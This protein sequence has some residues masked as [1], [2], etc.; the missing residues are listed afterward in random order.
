MVFTYLKNVRYQIKA[1]Y[2]RNLA[3][4]HHGTASFVHDND[5]ERIIRMGGRNVVSLGRRECMGFIA[6]CKW[7]EGKGYYDDD[8]VG[9]E[10]YMF[11]EFLYDKAIDGKIKYVGFAMQ[12]MEKGY[13]F[14]DNQPKVFRRFEA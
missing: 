9:M 7:G 6:P 14:Y 1:H 2:E 3:Y 5:I 11:R 4:T 10:L 12:R 8:E 13:I